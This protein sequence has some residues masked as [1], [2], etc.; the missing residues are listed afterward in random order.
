ML[1]NFLLFS[2][3]YFQIQKSVSFLHFLS[4]RFQSA[5]GFLGKSSAFYEHIQ[6]VKLTYNGFKPEMFLSFMHFKTSY[7]PKMSSKFTFTCLF[8]SDVSGS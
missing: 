5:L 4:K 6:H 1:S 7:L 8:V 2:A 3:S